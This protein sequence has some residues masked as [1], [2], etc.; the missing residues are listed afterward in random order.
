[1]KYKK[2]IVTILTILFFS[3]CVKNEKPKL[4]LKTQ[5]KILAAMNKSLV[6]TEMETIQAYSDSLE[7]SLKRTNTGLYYKIDSLSAKLIYDNNCKVLVA[8]V[9]ENLQA[10]TLYSSEISGLKTISVTN[11]NTESGLREGLKLM[12]PYTKAIFILP[13]FLAFGLQGDGNK[14]VGPQPLLY[15]IE[16]IS[17]KQP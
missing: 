11:S 8:Y 14:V 15:R 4:P 10:D 13:H 5:M 6:D 16:I 2:I 1:M 3:A 9:V 7:L 17:V 12:S